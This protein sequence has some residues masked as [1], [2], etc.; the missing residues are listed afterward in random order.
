VV[1]LQRLLLVETD[2]EFRRLLEQVAGPISFLV[3]AEDFPSARERLLE[4]SFDLL[5]TNVR[6][7]AYNGL[8]LVYLLKATSAPTRALVYGSLPETFLAR[9]AQRAGAFY[10]WSSRAL[11]SLPAYISARLPA[12]D[13]RDPATPDRRASYRGGRRRS[14]VPLSAGAST[15]V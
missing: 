12:Y 15:S 4:Q 14:D 10:E 9:E 2:P 13:R 7:R 6:L 1:R 5:V 3:S 11:Y 8:H